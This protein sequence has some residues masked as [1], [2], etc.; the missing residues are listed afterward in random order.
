MVFKQTVTWSGLDAQVNTDGQLNV[1]MY[2]TV[3]GTTTTTPVLCNP[4]GALYT[5]SGVV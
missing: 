5:I 2:A 3:S 1:I 4:E